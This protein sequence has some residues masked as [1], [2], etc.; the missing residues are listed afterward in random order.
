M[1][2]VRTEN[3]PITFTGQVANYGAGIQNLINER[4]FTDTAQRVITAPNP[5]ADD[6][7]YNNLATG[8][9]PR[10]DKINT[11]NNKVLVNSTDGQYSPNV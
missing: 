7:F 6:T 11:A 1:V 3:R 8:S 4:F 10:R 2:L 5:D 9:F